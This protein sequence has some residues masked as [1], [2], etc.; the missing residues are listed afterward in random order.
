MLGVTAVALLFPVLVF[1]GTTARL[2]AVRREQRFAAMR[3]VGATP[4][5]VTVV[6]AVESSVAAVVGTLAGFGLFAAAPGAAEHPSAHRRAVLPVRPGPDGA[7]RAPRRARRARRRAC[8]AAALAVRRVRISPLGV[9]R[10]TT[11]RPPRAYRLVPLLAGVAELLW[12]LDRRPPTT[13]GQLWAYLGGIFLIMGGLVIAGPWLTMVAARTLARVSN[14]PAG[15]LAA[16]RLADDPRSGF[17]AVSGLALALFVASTAVGVMT[18]MVPE[19]GAPTGD[20]AA[21][22]TLAGGVHPRPHARRASRR[23]RST[24]CPLRCSPTCRRSTACGAGSRC[25]PTRSGPRCPTAGSC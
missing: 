20:V 24:R 1:I 4:R 8:V 10:R 19:R 16:R 11:P 7:R 22:R 5:Q 6:A 18:T 3:L 17:R 2:A 25:T 15:L 14:R 12:F 13:T 9:S 23:S 21:T